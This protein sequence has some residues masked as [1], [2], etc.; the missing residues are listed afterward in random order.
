MKKGRISEAPA[1][2]TDIQ[3]RDPEAEDIIIGLPHK[4]KMEVFRYD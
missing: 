4:I 1:S 2:N 3:P